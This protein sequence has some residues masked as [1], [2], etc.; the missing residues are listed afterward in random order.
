MC[1]GFFFFLISST[2]PRKLN[3]TWATLIPKFEGAQEI[4]DYRPSS[5]VGCVYK[6][7]AKV[8]AN[9]LK[10]VMGQLVGETQSAFG[11]RRQIL[12]GA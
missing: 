3:I 2:L 4:K 1:F 8:L 10:I 7:I 6:M 9:R 12:D 5:M 11:Q